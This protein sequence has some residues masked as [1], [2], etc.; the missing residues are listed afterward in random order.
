[1]HN[2]V[3]QWSSEGELALI[4][5]LEDENLIFYNP[6]NDTWNYEIS[7]VSQ[8]EGVVRYTQKHYLKDG[9]SH[10]FNGVPCSTQMSVSTETPDTLTYSLSSPDIPEGL[11][12][13]MQRIK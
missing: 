7:G 6:P 12:G 3:G 9:S 2:L 11:S 4:I 1:M 10:P 13:D 5:K 8:N